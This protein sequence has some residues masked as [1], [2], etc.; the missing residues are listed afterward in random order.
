MPKIHV[1]FI[2]HTEGL[3]NSYQ[4][5]VPAMLRLRD[6][7]EQAAGKPFPLTW[8]LAT[9]HAFDQKPIFEEYRDT[10]LRL[11]DRGDEMALHPHGVVKDKK[12]DVDPF[13]AE[14]TRRLCAAGFPQPKTI[15][16]G[17]WSFYP[18][19]LAIIEKLGYAV[20]ASVVAGPTRQRLEDE[21]GNVY[22]DFPP[23]EAIVPGEA[24]M[25]PYRL[26][27]ES[28]VRR[29]SSSV[30]EVPVCGHVEGMRS[31]PQDIT[32]S[33][34]DLQRKRLAST[35][36]E[37]FEVFWHPWELL[38]DFLSTNIEQQTVKNLKE[39]LLRIAPDPAVQFS[40]V[41]QAAMDWAAQ[42]GG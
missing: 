32:V 39:F 24:F 26:S 35:G 19:T 9:F 6:E 13:I 38:G 15:A 23:S 34:F 33:R 3:A 7:V 36:I 28:V 37:V 40:T 30:I 2:C 29:G 18:G 4:A 21:N 14:D 25:V 22:Y 16:V 42:R 41:Y 5:G 10:F 17:T 20:D 12:W 11:L 1:C 27:R 31:G 8:A